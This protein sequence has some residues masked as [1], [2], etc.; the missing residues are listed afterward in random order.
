MPFIDRT[1]RTIDPYLEW[2]VRLF[3]LG[4]GFAVIAMFL[5]IG[6]LL[7][8]A[9]GLLGVGF[10]LRFLTRRHEEALRR[11]SGEWGSEEEEDHR[12]H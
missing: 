10:A 6:W 8:V 9:A 11:E 1:S 2:K 5:D 4:A 3:V 12:A 7:A